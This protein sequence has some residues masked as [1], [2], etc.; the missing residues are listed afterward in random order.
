MN[1][2]TPLISVVTVCLNE[3]YLERTCES[4][5]N[6]TFQDFEWIVI[7]GG[8]NEATLAIFEKY[9]SRMDYFVSESDGGIYF[10]MNKGIQQANGKWVNFLN[11]GDCFAQN[12]VL[13]AVSGHIHD[14]MTGS[15][16]LYG[17]YIITDGQDYNI[18]KNPETID[19]ECLFYTMPHH[20]TCFF[21][22]QVF[23]S[24]GHYN[25]AYS[26]CADWDFTLNLLTRHQCAFYKIDVPIL[27]YSQDGRSAAN[28]SK[29]FE[30]LSKIRSM[31][32]SQEEIL[33]FKKKQAQQ[34]RFLLKREL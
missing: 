10:G 7:D 3:P 13:S 20:E 29:I 12:S 11:A 5:V 25:T 32:F 2:N 4:I 15:T 30:E 28:K 19:K 14:G 1:K 22:K 23:E 31:Y 27:V 8:S 17:D 16:V 6:Q 21:K 34:V 33:M 9:K 18:M 26:L 24:Y